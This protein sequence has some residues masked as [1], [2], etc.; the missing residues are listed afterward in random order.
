MNSIVK[1]TGNAGLPLAI[2]SK[3]DYKPC[4]KNYNNFLTDNG[5]LVN[6]ESVKAFFRH[7]KDIYSFS[8]QAKHKA[9]IKAAILRLCKL[10]GNDSSLNRIEID[11]VFKEIKI[12]NV[13]Y[14]ISS[15][16]HITDQEID[17]MVAKC[18]LKTA[19]IISALRQ[20]GCRITELLDIKLD[21]CQRTRAGIQIEIVRRKANRVDRVFMRPELFEDIKAVYK[22][23][24]YLFENVKTGRPITRTNAYIL[25]NKAG[26]YIESDR[27][28]PHTIRHTFAIVTMPEL[29]LSKTS[30]LLGHSSTRV[31]AEYY[32]GDIATEAEVFGVMPK[33][34]RRSI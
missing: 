18:G 14:K 6:E 30:A 9:A 17:R 5:Y 1:T 33:Y 23:N 20:T 8:H 12:P 29:G 22:G 32:L 31:T 2:T 25:I 26:F 4:L 11:R 34:K 7:I 24:K 13:K 27:I 19:L 3:A 15:L 21:K 16:K 10:Q 28:H